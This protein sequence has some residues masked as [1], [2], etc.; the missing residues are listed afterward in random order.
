MGGVDIGYPGI[1]IDRYRAGSWIEGPTASD[2]TRTDPRAGGV[3]SNQRPMTTLPP[4]SPTSYAYTLHFFFLIGDS[5]MNSSCLAVARA[6]PLVRVRRQ[7]PLLPY[8]ASAKCRKRVR[9]DPHRRRCS[10]TYEITGV[11]QSNRVAPPTAHRGRGAPFPQFRW[12][13]RSHMLRGALFPPPFCAMIH[14]PTSKPPTTTLPGHRIY[15]LILGASPAVDMATQPP[16]ASVIPPPTAYYRIPITTYTSLHPRAPTGVCQTPVA[17]ADVLEFLTS[18]HVTVK[19][20]GVIA[21]NNF[22]RG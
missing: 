10:Y 22:E 20:Y 1:A 21:N 14:L 15:H 3:T 4:P 13:P 19:R 11:F 6:S 7:G 18:V 17:L 2:A 16:N 8:H 12:V 9:P 5:K